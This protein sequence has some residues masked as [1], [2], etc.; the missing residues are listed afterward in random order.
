MPDPA[1]LCDT[2]TYPT[3]GAIQEHLLDVFISAA[4]RACPRRAAEAERRLAFLAEYLVN[5]RE[6]TSLRWWDLK[7][8]APRGLVPVVVGSVCG[9]AAAVQSALATHVGV[10]VGIG[11]GTGL[12]IA[13]AAGLGIR[14]A[15]HVT[16][17]VRYAELAK[18]RN[19]GPGMAGG[20]AGAALGGVAAGIAGRL[21]IGHEAALFSGLPEA[22]GIGLGAG[23]STR[24]AGGLSGGLLGAFAG[25]LLEGVG[26]GLPAGL[27]NGLGVGLTVGLAVKY[28]GLAR[29]T[30]FVTGACRIT[31]PSPARLTASE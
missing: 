1:S 5:V 27:V 2:E 16:D 18:D 21:G 15:T 30:S 24:F 26:R 28:V 14:Y 31:W 12:L 13:L 6:T 25:G 3:P 17:P 20:L 23:A 22:L 8:L 29:T 11:V 19:P 7:G 9:I 10:G 4:Y